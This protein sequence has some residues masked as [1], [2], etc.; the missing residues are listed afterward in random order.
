MCLKNEHRKFGIRT[1]EKFGRY[2]KPSETSEGSDLSEGLM[3]SYMLNA[4]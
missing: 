4:L 3:F 1:V 2:E